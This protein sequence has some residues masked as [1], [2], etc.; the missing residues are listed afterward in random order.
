[1]LR[2]GDDT[3]RLWHMRFGT[4]W[5]KCFPDFDKVRHVQK[6][7]TTRKLDF[8]E[9][10]VI[11]RPEASFNI[12]RTRPIF[13]ILW[14]EEL[15]IGMDNQYLHSHSW[16]CY[17]CLGLFDGSSLIDTL[18]CCNFELEISPMWRFI[19]FWLNFQESYLT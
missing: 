2:I 18:S 10:C 19:E 9:R 4:C 3:S 11:R 15:W 14:V 5:R 16:W 13:Y 8:Y 6:K 7:K 17:L 1:M 12:I